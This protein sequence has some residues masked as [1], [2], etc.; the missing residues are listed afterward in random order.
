VEIS[1]TAVATAAVA[2]A[3][4]E[5]PA[6]FISYAR[7]DEKLVH[8]LRE[9]LVARDRDVWVDWEDIRKGEE[10]WRRIELGIESAAAV[11]AVLSP[12]F[13]ESEPCADEIEHAVLNN[14][15]LLPVMC[16]DVPAKALRPELARINW[17]DFG[18]ELEFEHAVDELVHALATDFQWLDTHA[19]YNERAHEWE[20]SGRDA[21]FH[22]QRNQLTAA[23]RWL[24]EQEQHE[25]RATALQTEYILASRRAASRRL[26]ITLA[27]V[28]GMLALAIVLG[29][30]AWLQRGEAVRQSNAA[31]ARELSAQA[32]LVR[33]EDAS[34]L[35]TSVLLGVEGV[36]RAREQSA[37][38]VLPLQ[39]GLALLPRRH[40]SVRLPAAV[41]D[42]AV[43]PT[44][45][46][47]IVGTR[48]GE[49]QVRDARTGRLERV[50]HLRARVSAVTLGARGTAVAG[51]ADGDVVVWSGHGRRVAT[52]LRLPDTVT[53]VAV[54]R[55]GRYVIAGSYDG[56]V[57]LWDAR[58]AR[59][60]TY[61]Q[62]YH[63]A[64]VAF[65]DDSR[66]F[67]V[68][69]GASAYVDDESGGAVVVRRVRSGR[70]VKRFALAEEAN[71]V[72]FSP[73]GTFND[74][75]ELVAF[76][77]TDATAWLWDVASRTMVARL[78]HRQTVVDIAFSPD[79][80]RVATASLDGTARVWATTG[81]EVALFSQRAP[82]TTIA[83]SPDGRLVATGSWDDTARVWRLEGGR[84]VAR[85]AHAG[86]VEHV[87]FS[88]GGSRLVSTSA[89]RIDVSTAT[90]AAERLMLPH[91]HAFS[92]DGRRALVNQGDADVVWDLTTLRPLVR[93]PSTRTYVGGGVLNHD[94]TLVVQDPWEEPAI[95]WRV[96]S[97]RRERLVTLV[98]PGPNAG[99][100][101]DARGDR[102]VVARGRTAIVWS[103]KA[104]V[105]LR[106]IAVARPLS[107][108]LI[109]PDGR[110]LVTVAESASGGASSQMLV[111]NVDD[112]RRAPRA[113]VQRGRFWGM[114]FALGGQYLVAGRGDGAVRVWRTDDWTVERELRGEQ[115]AGVSADGTLMLATG[116][117]G[118]ISVRRVRDGGLRG[119]VVA[120]GDVVSV[121]GDGRFLVTA[122]DDSVRVWEVTSG[123]GLA[124]IPHEDATDVAFTADNR[125]V[126]VASQTEADARAARVWAWRAEDLVMAACSRLER[127]LTRE[128]W[129]RFVP[130]RE[131]R[132]TCPS[133]PT[134]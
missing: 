40:A 108:A 38:S 17:I 25:E 71:A 2:D 79:G 46:R 69:S 102:L 73:G 11:V 106:R 50:R 70:V 32:D 84:E 80:D 67:A 72:A 96:D 85:L 89:R 12:E 29:V 111:W 103:I 3:Q 88:G 97:G 82:I 117:G 121:S 83:F 42:V 54:D 26:Q 66:L 78:R 130:D 87:A 124:R 104:R 131:Y 75:G 118:R 24:D 5:R 23:E 60:R 10:W 77:S 52:R 107:E 19:R 33:S 47:M 57:L 31:L 37:E 100:A 27:G 129:Q 65:S 127:N 22:L 56:S 28:A 122:G 120:G 43:D 110:T 7:E 16:R 30:V 18:Q 4:P 20:R 14:K 55:D 90:G 74:A 132:R 61:R 45:R 48:A 64:D 39:L 92:G 116:R 53:A 13:V 59:R 115:P 128:E 98:A 35:P 49:V 6:V 62:R 51:S 93:I 9:S 109:S 125:H 126:V 99:V 58:T 123:R 95:V 76:A 101:F 15:R 63:V 1:T 68:A 94:G 36:E 81:E 133:L 44:G 105:E 91:L 113:L 119:A 21:S 114:A 112:A 134:P 8:R 34:L 41:G 86:E